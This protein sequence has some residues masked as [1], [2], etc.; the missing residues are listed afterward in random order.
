MKNGLKK[1]YPVIT[2]IMFNIV[3]TTYYI[4]SAVSTFNDV[5][6]F[7]IGNFFFFWNIFTSES[8]GRSVMV[9]M[10]AIR[11]KIPMMKKGTE[12]PNKPFSTEPTMGPNSTP[13]AVIVSI[14]PNFFW[15]SFGQK[16]GI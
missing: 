11:K 13:N 7:P 10:I 2:E 8:E 16:R 4:I 14:I 9:G 5:N 15:N 3:I 6:A 1:I 12:Y